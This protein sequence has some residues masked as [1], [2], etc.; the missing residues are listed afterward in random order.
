[1]TDP[2]SYSALANDF[3]VNQ[4][5]NLKMD[6]PSNRETI[7]NMF[8]RVRRDFP[9]MERFRRMESELALE[10]D[11]TAGPAGAEQ[12]WL[13]MRR[14]SVRSG[15]VNPPTMVAAY[16]LH[17]LVLEI[18]PYFLSISPLDVDFVELL[19]GF[20]IFAE[21]NHDAI[22]FDALYS[23]TPLGRL[24][25]PPAGKR[26]SDAPQPGIPID[27][28]P[29]MG[30]ALTEA[31]D[32]QAYFEVKTRTPTRS[33]KSGEFDPQPIS[34]FLTLRKYGAVKDVS[35]LA[36][37]FASLS[38]RGEEL[39][40]TRVVPGLVMPIREAVGEAGG[41]NFDGHDGPESGNGGSPGR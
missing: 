23:G 16:K 7:L 40:E 34:I 14:T 15:I 2:R 41:S 17:K 37:I 35:E 6:L 18:A 20:D 36:D 9:G 38:S 3:Y 33:V 26:K 1:M 31:C 22:I 28:Q 13:A 10:S 24:I 30:M 39:L 4:R 8:D 5:L 19:F 11:P 21:G 25:E 29:V 32:L 27:C 12:M